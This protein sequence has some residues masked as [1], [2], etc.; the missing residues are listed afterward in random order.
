MSMKK[1]F[2]AR[3]ATQRAIAG[4]MSVALVTGGLAVV[5]PAS[6][7]ENQCAPTQTVRSSNGDGDLSVDEVYKAGDIITVSAANFEARKAGENLGIKLDYGNV[8]WAEDQNAADNLQRIEAGTLELNGDKVGDGNFEFKVALPKDIKDGQHIITVLG[9]LS[10]GVQVVKHISFLVNTSGDANN[11]CLPQTSTQSTESS[12]SQAPSEQPAPSTPAQP[13]EPTAS[14]AS[15]NITKAAIYAMKNRRGEKGDTLIELSLAGFPKGSKVKAVSEGLE[16]KAT[17]TIGNNGS[18]T[19]RFI[20]PVGLK[21]GEH[22]ISFVADGAEVE[23]TINL[24]ASGGVS[25]N[26]SQGATVVFHGAGL[27]EGA[28]IT[29]VG[30]N[31]GNWLADDQTA[32][33][34]ATGLVTIEDVKIPADAPFGTAITFTYN[35]DGKDYERTS[36]T[37]VNASS[38]AI[39]LDNYTGQKAELPTGLYQ[40][41]INNKTGHVFVSR[42]TGTTNSSLY[43]VDLKTR[44]VVAQNNDLPKAEDGKTISAFGLGVDNQRGLVWVTNTKQD[45]VSVFT[46]DKLEL[47]HTFPLKSASHAREVVVDERTGLAYVSAAGANADVVVVYDLENKTSHTIKL[48]GFDRVMGL[49]FNEESGELFTVSLNTSK[50]ARIDV[51]NGDKVTLYDLPAD[52]VQSASGIAYD[53]KTKHA[54]VA[55][56]VTGNTYVFN[57]ED[58]KEVA[59]I[60]TGAGALNAHYSKADGKVYVTNREGG[61]IT[62]IDPQTNKVVANL[63]AGKYPNYVAVA[64]DGTIVAV[65]K[66]AIKKDDGT[67]VDELYVYNPKD[68]SNGGSNQGSQN[69]SSAGNSSD[70]GSSRDDLNKVSQDRPAALRALLTAVVGAFAVFGLL[71]SAFAALVKLNIVPA[72]WIPQQ[73]RL[74]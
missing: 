23:T 18:A 66:A 29:R 34:D 20:L 14:E 40:A 10:G 26:G 27:P 60:P 16:S 54:F 50:A 38:D 52:K 74:F 43:K 46:Q 3:T 32:T 17:V 4:L 2:I 31:G 36:E 69:G 7:Q 65:N 21:E 5:T 48:D 47:V 24:E 73:W 49:E 67:T 51:R 45:T 35:V 55:S 22:K 39:N 70:A 6:A 53:P 37:I 62:V 8:E 1:N 58:G 63:P 30:V 9:G 61:T 25:D 12:T 15:V 41:G 13:A 28:K 71:S 33:A 68:S 56:Q 42:A 57:T 19:G 72:S 44:E 64:A 59:N 11:P